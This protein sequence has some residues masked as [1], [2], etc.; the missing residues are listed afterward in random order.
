ME[1]YYVI[2]YFLFTFFASFGV[3]Q[4]ALSTGSSKRINFGIVVIIVSYFWFF[5]SS[6]RNIPTFLEGVQLFVIFGLA[7]GLAVFITKN[8]YLLIKNK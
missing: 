2:D 8:L 3:L 6:D 1:I 7:A 4:I 5:S